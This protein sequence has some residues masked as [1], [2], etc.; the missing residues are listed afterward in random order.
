MCKTEMN[1]VNPQY[2]VQYNRAFNAIRNRIIISAA[3]LGKSI[4]VRVIGNGTIITREGGLVVKLFNTNVMR[5]DAIKTAVAGLDPEQFNAAAIDDQSAIDYL[6]KVQNEGSI[7][8]TVP[9]TNRNAQS[10][11]QGAIVDCTVVEVKLRTGEMALALNFNRV[12]PAENGV[13]AASAFDQLMA[14]TGVGSS[15]SAGHEDPFAGT[16]DTPPANET[17]AQ[18][19]ARLKREAATV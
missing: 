6:R 10:V 5:A 9:V 14:G 12:I 3:D 16:S 1:T 17:A 11:D 19:K 13:S 8:F 2:S 7:P 4:K 15:D 18:K